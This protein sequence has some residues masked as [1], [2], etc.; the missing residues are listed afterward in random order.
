MITSA[1]AKQS[2][3]YEFGM[4]SFTPESTYYLG[5]SSTNPAESVT[6]PAASTGYARV[7]ILNNAE[8]WGT[9]ASGEYYLHNIKTFEFP[10]LTEDAGTVSH[11]FLSASPTE[12]TFMYYGAL[13]VPRNMPAESQLILRGGDMK[14]Y[15]RNAA[16]GE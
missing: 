2:L 10:V 16:D 14:I 8:S 13:D 11:W 9:V 4:R 6:E 7:A 3:E 12:N 15:R 5:L 1:R